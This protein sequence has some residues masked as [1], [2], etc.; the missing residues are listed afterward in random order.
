MLVTVWATLAI[1]AAY[2][3]ALPLAMREPLHGSGA[4]QAAVGLGG[5][6]GVAGI[7]A[8]VEGLRISRAEK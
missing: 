4:L 8:A 6:A 2:P 1:T 5:L 3:T 7:K